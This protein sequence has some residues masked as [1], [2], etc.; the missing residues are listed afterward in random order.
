[1]TYIDFLNGAIELSKKALEGATPHEAKGI[2]KDIQSLESMK[3]TYIN[4]LLARQAD[5]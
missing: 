3:E 2:K 4:R 1:M 5:L